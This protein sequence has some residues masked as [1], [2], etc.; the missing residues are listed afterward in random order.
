MTLEVFQLSG[1]TVVRGSGR[2]DEGL[3]RLVGLAGGVPTSAPVVIDLSEMTLDRAA[4]LRTLI[5]QLVESGGAVCR[6]IVVCR[7]MSAR[8]MVRRAA[9]GTAVPVVATLEEA[10]RIVVPSI[11]VRAGRPS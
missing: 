11:G 6:A 10:L 9:V 7:R 4:L 5:H 8:R 1:A 2:L 3:A